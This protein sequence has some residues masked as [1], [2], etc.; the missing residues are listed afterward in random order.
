MNDDRDEKEMRELFEALRREDERVA[1]PFSRSWESALARMRKPS[2]AWRPLRAVAAATVLTLL[3]VFVVFSVHPTR[4]PEWG[5]GV[6][7]WRSPTNSLLTSLDDPL[8]KTV[9][10]LGGPSVDIKLVMP[11]KK[12]GGLR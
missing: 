12:S 5:V 6:S 9:P 8:L 1:P 4:P 11:D 3:G 7:E 10:R 2:R